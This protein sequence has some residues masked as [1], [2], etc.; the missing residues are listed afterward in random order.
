MFCFQAEGR[1]GLSREEQRVWFL[2]IQ[3]HSIKMACSVRTMIKIVWAHADVSGYISS[4][5]GLAHVTVKK[6]IF[7]SLEVDALHCMYC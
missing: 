3:W 6:N 5:L 4:S 1:N 2:G 7:F